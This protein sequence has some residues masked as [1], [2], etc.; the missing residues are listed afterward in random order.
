MEAVPPGISLT[1]TIVVSSM[2]VTIYD[3]AR[4]AGVGI[5]TVS[6]CLNNHPSVAPE[7]RQK[8]LA[9]IKRLNYQPHAY[10]HRLASRKTNT[11][12]AIIPFFT[13][14][15][16]LEVLKG[17]QDRALELGI[18]LILSG[19]NDPSQ[20]EYYLRRSLLRGHVDGVMFFSMNFPESFVSKFQEI[21]LPLV[22]VDTHH[23]KFDSITVKNREGAKIAVEHLIHLGHR[24]IAI[25]NGNLQARPAGERLAG[26]REALEDHDIP[27][28]DE[29]MLSSGAGK[30]DGFTREAGR[31]L[32]R[33]LISR[34]RISDTITAAFV[35]SDVQAIGVLEGARELGIRIPDDIA[36]VSFDDIELAQ[37]ARLTTMRQPMYQMGRLAVE[38]LLD[39]IKERDAAPRITSFLPELVIRST[40]GALR[41]GE[42]AA[43]IRRKKEL[44]AI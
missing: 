34:R 10:A 26:Y 36:I 1:S 12:S 24:S 32:I 9:V 8:V 23:N 11:I 40:C 27:L 29:W 33:E 22:L 4:E 44:Q 31:T 3:L 28:R 19:V 38:Q 17:V 15:F 21:A 7:T 43:R 20:V 5:G 2:G 37:H 30:L 16:F 35:A 6:R 41:D 25:I 39:R 14:Y 13:N 18:D 42:A